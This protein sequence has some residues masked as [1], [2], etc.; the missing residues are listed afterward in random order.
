[1]SMWLPARS[2]AAEEADLVSLTLF[3]S[4]ITSVESIDPQPE[5]ITEDEANNPVLW[6][7]R[8]T[9]LRKIKF[10]DPNVYQNS[11]LRTYAIFA[12]DTGDAVEIMGLNN[13]FHGTKRVSEGR[14]GDLYTNAGLYVI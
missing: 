12:G 14:I 5:K 1:M 11:C 8:H 9:F 13:P 4:P 7:K 6:Y 10:A 2:A 3:M